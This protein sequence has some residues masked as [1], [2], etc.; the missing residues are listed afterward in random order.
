MY[1]IFLITAASF[2]FCIFHVSLS[3]AQIRVSAETSGMLT[4][5][6]AAPFWLQSNRYGIYSAEKNQFLTRLGA[7]KDFPLSSGIRLLT[8]AA[9]IAR[10][11]NTSTLSFNEL[12]I[13]LY[14]YGLE[15][16][17]GR[18]YNTSPTHN[19]SLGMGSLGI[20]R[21]AA[22][23]PQIRIGLQDWTSI[24]FTGEFVQVK[25]HL[26]HGWLGNNRFTENP[27]LHEKTGYIRFGG[28]LPVNIYGGLAHYAIWSGTHPED[29][30]VPARFSDFMDVFLG[31]A[32]DTYTPGA[33][34][35]YA[36][37]NHLGAW[38]FGFFLETDPFNI[39]AYRQFPLETKDNLKFKSFQD[40]LTGI[41][42]RFS[43]ESPFP[44]DEFVY[45]Y[46][47][48]KHQDGPRRYNTFGDGQLCIDFPEQCRDNYRGNENYY[49]HEFYKTGWVYQ[50]KTMG[51]PLFTAAEQNRGVFNNRVI[52]HHIGMSSDIGR[53]RLTGKAT[54][55]RNYGKRCDNR[56]PDLGEGDLFEIQCT[57]IIVNSGGISLDQW[58]FMLGAEQPLPVRNAE[59]FTVFIDLAADT[60]KIAGTQF[61]SLFGIRWT[62]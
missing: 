24:P 23:V 18:F 53:I 52:A 62:P 32:G 10:P 2:F 56:I 33:D 7:E 50:T 11:G 22:P 38:D 4:T 6:D 31:L 47:Y 17:A 37:G 34:Q 27:L 30:R 42:V 46:L 12:Y 45:E 21:N 48:S 16:A 15:V 20:S 3:H 5:G 51:N 44:L 40:A 36:L 29:G 19:E 14:G 25:G 41:S 54:Y 61:G 26:A 57:D 60:G 39:T 59:N 49:N 28:R 9:L 13:K 58:S 43:E 8:G 1:R 35:A 55:S